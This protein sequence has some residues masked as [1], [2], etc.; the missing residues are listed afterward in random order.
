MY[1]NAS[2]LIYVKGSDVVIVKSEEGV[3]QGNPLG[4][5][6]FSAA[7]QPI[8]E[9]LQENHNNLTVLTYLGDLFVVVEFVRMQPFVSDLQSSLK[10]VRLV[11]NEKSVSCSM[12]QILYNLFV[13][14]LWSHMAQRF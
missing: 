4:P 7:L 9:S 8:L 11:V 6:L 12:H 14:F 3:H 5:F 13:L 1:S 2:S 10:D